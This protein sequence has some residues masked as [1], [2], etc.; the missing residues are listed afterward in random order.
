MRA[1]RAVGK[2]AAVISEISDSSF[3]SRD[4]SKT[5]P[6]AAREFLAAAKIAE[7]FRFEEARDH[8]IADTSGSIP[9]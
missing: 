6:G 4:N 9:I 7:C 1:D 8:G 5:R 3:G 2:L